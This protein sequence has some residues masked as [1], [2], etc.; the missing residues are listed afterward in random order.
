VK[1]SPAH[2]RETQKVRHTVRK[3][4]TLYRIA[5]QYGVSVE[6]LRRENRIARR[7]S[8]RVGQRLSVP[9]DAGR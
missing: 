3:G 8:I 6:A 7:A 4:E 5:N 2:R 1:A 9:G